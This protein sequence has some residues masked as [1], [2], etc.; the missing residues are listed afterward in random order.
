[1]AEQLNEKLNYIP[2]EQHPGIDADQDQQFFEEELEINDF[3]QQVRWRVCS[4][5]CVMMID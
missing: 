2:S 3:P 4:R 1:L 5:V